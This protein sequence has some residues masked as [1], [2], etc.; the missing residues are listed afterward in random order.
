[1]QKRWP[2]EAKRYWNHSSHGSGFL[3]EIMASQLGGQRS[4]EEEWERPAHCPMPV[5]IEQ[6]HECTCYLP[7]LPTPESTGMPIK[8][9]G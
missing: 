3:E 9:G 4:G 2:D 6:G 8:G 1:M 5:D 7:F